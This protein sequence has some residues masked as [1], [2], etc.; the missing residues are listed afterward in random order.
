MGGLEKEGLAKDWIKLGPGFTRAGRSLRTWAMAE[1]NRDYLLSWGG[2][3]GEKT[4]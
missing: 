2:L 4:F 3:R 1:V